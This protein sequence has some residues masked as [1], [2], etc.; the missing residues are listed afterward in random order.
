MKVF[1]GDIERAAVGQVSAVAE[2]HA[3]HRIAGL[4][5]REVGGHVG[6]RTGVGLYVGVLRSE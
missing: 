2:A 3:Q 6:L 1:A 5:Q 4:Q